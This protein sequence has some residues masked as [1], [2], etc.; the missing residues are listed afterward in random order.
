MNYLICTFYNESVK[1]Y[2]DTITNRIILLSDFFIKEIVTSTGKT[3]KKQ[4]Q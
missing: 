2:P 1:A 3:L 4:E